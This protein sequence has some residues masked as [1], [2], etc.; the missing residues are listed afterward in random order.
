MADSDRDLIQQAK[1]LLGGNQQALAKALAITPSAI[2]NWLTANR[3][4]E[5]SR[6]KLVALLEQLQ[7]GQ[8]PS[9][10]PEAA[11]TPAPP[12]D[13]PNWPDIHHCGFWA[14]SA[15]CFN[16]LVSPQ[17]EGDPGD[18][19]V[20]RTW[21]GLHAS[22]STTFR[23]YFRYQPFAGRGP[24]R[25]SAPARR[26]DSRPPEAE[27]TARAL[28]SKGEPQGFGF[29]KG[30]SP[31]AWEQAHLQGTRIEYLDASAELVPGS[32]GCGGYF[33][34]AERSVLSQA[35][36]ATTYEFVGFRPECPVKELHLVLS[37][38]RELRGAGPM[39][40]YLM[41]TD[42]PQYYDFASRIATNQG[43]LD[44]LIEP[45][46]RS[47]PVDRLR[48]E[49]LQKWDKSK[50]WATG[51]APEDQELVRRIIELFRAEPGRDVSIATVLAPPSLTTLLMFWPLPTQRG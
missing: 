5:G 1:H 51:W 25:R 3:I 8:H 40:A 32:H 47:V 45:W 49:Q 9:Y 46:G 14:E 39:V 50:S 10:P 36:A 11:P 48:P 35:D 27:L 13:V 42:Y 31:P 28:P 26:Y 21:N 20:W 34:R 19:N 44:R 17:K 22:R 37:L 24:D 7:R 2:S 6:Q 33:V 41:S 23:H 29:L 4:P 15:W 18:D 16:Y 30:W 43:E 38:P 12:S